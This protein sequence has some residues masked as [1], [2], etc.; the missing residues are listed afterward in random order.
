MTR[1]PSGGMVVVVGG[2]AWRFL[3]EWW[4]SF[5]CAVALHSLQA[6]CESCDDGVDSIDTVE[7]IVVSILLYSY[8]LELKNDQAL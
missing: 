3:P 2:C 5:F 8:I 4:L 1:K 6:V 7:E